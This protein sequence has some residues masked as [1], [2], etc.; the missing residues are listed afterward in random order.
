MVD[1]SRTLSDQKF[2]CGPESMAFEYNEFVLPYVGVAIMF[3]TVVYS[4]YENSFHRL[5][6]GHR[7]GASADP[8]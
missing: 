8:R 4:R 7:H 5:L 3:F 1:E 2:Y 6:V